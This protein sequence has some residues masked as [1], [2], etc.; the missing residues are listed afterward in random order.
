MFKIFYRSVSRQWGYNGV[1][2]VTY[3]IIL[4]RLINNRVDNMLNSTAYTRVI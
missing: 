2:V 1:V 3:Y 4:Y